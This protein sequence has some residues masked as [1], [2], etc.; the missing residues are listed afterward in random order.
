MTHMASIIKD[1]KRDPYHNSKH[2][3]SKQK[4]NTS[5][6]KNRNYFLKNPMEILEPKSIIS[7]MKNGLDEVQV[8]KRQS[9]HLPSCLSPWIQSI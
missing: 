2:T 6:Q 1:F 5:Q 3:W 8:L 4:K 7:E 9:K